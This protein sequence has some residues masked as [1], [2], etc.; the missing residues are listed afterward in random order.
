MYFTSCFGV[1]QGGVLSPQLFNEFL[2]DL[3]DYLDPECGVKLDRKLLLYL[4]FADDLILFSHSAMVIYN[5]AYAVR[6]CVFKYGDKVIEIVNTY[7]YLGVWCSN[8]N[9]LLSEN[10]A[11]LS[12]KGSCQAKNNSKNP[13]K[14]RIV[15]TPTTLPPIHFFFFCKHVQRQKQHTKTQ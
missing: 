14:T 12:N 7:K 13:R 15:Q 6:N 10:F 4:L 11:Y 1:I 8:K 2:S 3:G 5:S 9:K